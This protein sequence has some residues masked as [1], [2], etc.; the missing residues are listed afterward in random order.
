MPHPFIL[1]STI[2]ALISPLIYARAIL[3]GEAKPHRTTRLVLLIITALTTASLFAQH[4]TVAIWLAGVST[5]QS[6]IVFTLSLKYGMGGHS[7]SDITCLVIALIGI[8]LWQVTK[9][10]IVALYFAILADFTGFAPTLVK[11]YK[12]PETEY[13][14]FFLMDVFAGIFSLLAVKTWAPEQI[15]YP[16]YILLINLVEVMLILR[17]N[18]LGKLKAK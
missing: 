13:Y 3:K 7:R 2:L 17:P 16:I 11:T 6:I 9:N 4:D 10:P 12:Q 18:I 1:I 5:L 8:V 14:L 15:S